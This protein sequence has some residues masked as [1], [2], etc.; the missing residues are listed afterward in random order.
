MTN[1]LDTPPPLPPAPGSAAAL[2]PQPFTR[3]L[4]DAM[5]LTRANLRRLF[6]TFA[7]GFGLVAAV[8]TA[9][10]AVVQAKTGFAA[11]GGAADPAQAL[12][13][14]IALLAV[15]VPV[16]LLQVVLFGA[17]T[18]AAVDVVAG[19]GADA[20]RSI[21]FVG[22][23]ARLGTVLLLWV[24][25][26]AS[27][28][29]CFVPVLYVGPLLSLTLP[30]MADEGLTGLDAL[31]RSAVLARYNPQRRLTTSTIARVL[32]LVAVLWVVSALIGLVVTLPVMGI[33]FGSM[34]HQ[35]ASGG[36]P[37]AVAPR[38]LWIQMPF[39]I[40][41]GAINAAVALYGGFATALLFTDVR[42][43]REGQDLQAA[44]SGM[45]P[46]TAPTLP[47]PPAGGWAP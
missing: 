30:V 37:Q 2:E 31:R 25:V 4:D 24:C 44:I 34:L 17:L 11:G 20:G 6:P 38:L 41:G 28:C 19:R 3:L 23:P 45:A 10:Q 12:A 33:T 40:L 26:G 7:V 15:L 43:R 39:F 35:I 29:C 46:P 47:P 42:R 14:V 36:N 1:G 27:A 22:R 16:L 8:Q 13:Y 5:R 18:V 32:A 21:R 9:L